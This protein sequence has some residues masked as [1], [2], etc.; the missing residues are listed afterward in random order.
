VIANLPPKRRASRGS[1]A[2]VK[3]QLETDGLDR[4][5]DDLVA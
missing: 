5:C 3:A 1:L 2:S 4:Q